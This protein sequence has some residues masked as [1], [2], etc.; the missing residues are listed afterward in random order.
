MAALAVYTG[1]NQRLGA[2]WRVEVKRYCLTG[3]DICFCQNHR[4]LVEEW[5][6]GQNLYFCDILQVGIGCNADSTRRVG[7]P[8]LVGVDNT[9]YVL[10]VLVDLFG[11]IIVEL[12]ST[13]A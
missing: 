1:G 10:G 4:I 9:K 6:L 11:R 12:L 13:T 2:S 7:M 3:C 5:R 8:I